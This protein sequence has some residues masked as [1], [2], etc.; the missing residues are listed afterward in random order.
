MVA[1]EFKSC[2]RPSSQMHILNKTLISQSHRALIHKTQVPTFW[3][4]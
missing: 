2:F 3:N 1:T 4:H